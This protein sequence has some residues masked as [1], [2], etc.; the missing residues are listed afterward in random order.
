MIIDWNTHHLIACRI[1]DLRLELDLELLS[2][3]LD[4]FKAILFL[5]LIMSTFV[6]PIE[7]TIFWDKLKLNVVQIFLV[8][9]AL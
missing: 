6:S 8:G 2:K 7:I 5:Y 9:V 1:G 3:L 4:F